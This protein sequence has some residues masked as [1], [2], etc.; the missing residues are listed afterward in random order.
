MNALKILL[1]ALATVTS[2][3]CT[4]LLLRGYLRS[5]VRLLFWSSLC[6]V[7]LTVNNI[8]LFADLVIFPMADLR[9]PRL[10][11]SMAGLACLLYAFV[12]ESDRNGGLK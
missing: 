5:R 9:L 10:I 8:L 6:F 3:A 12:W 7:G 11:A 4:V 1:Y 2:F